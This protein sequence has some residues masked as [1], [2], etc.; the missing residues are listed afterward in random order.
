MLTSYSTCYLSGPPDRDMQG[1][2]FIPLSASVVIFF[3]FISFFTHRHIECIKPFPVI[4]FLAYAWWRA[5]WLTIIVA[6]PHQ[7]GVRAPHLR[8][9]SNRSGMYK[10]NFNNF[11]YFPLRVMFKDIL[12]RKL[13]KCQFI[14]TF[15]Y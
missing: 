11:F 1:N 14:T 12:T 7:P 3:G 6:E 15:L 13:Y 5:A 9:H 10:H 8:H 4:R 2:Y